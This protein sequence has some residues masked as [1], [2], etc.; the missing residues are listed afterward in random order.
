MNKLQR[1]TAIQKRLD[2]L[3]AEIQA[4]RSELDV[5]LATWQAELAIL[6]S[7]VDREES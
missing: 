1:L 2:E 4:K 7:M 3:E 6:R 5:L